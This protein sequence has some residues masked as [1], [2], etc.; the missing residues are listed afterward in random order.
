MTYGTE[1]ST[2]AFKMCQFET[3]LRQL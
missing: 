3:G 1:M 2:F